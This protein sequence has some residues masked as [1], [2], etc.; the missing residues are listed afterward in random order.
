MERTTKLSGEHKA[1][2]GCEGQPQL[3][4]VT[5]AGNMYRAPCTLCEHPHH[6]TFKEAGW[7]TRS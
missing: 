4:R 7:T 5:P 2:H 3:D 1:R 6:L